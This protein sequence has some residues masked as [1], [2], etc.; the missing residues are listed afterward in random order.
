[1]KRPFWIICAVWLFVIAASACTLTTPNG[2][3]T[4]TMQPS[5]SFEEDVEVFGIGGTAL[6]DSNGNGR[7]DATDVPLAG[8]KFT[9]LDGSGKTKSGLTDDRGAVILGAP[10]GAVPIYPVTL[11]MEPPPGATY[12]VVGADEYTW[13]KVEL[14]RNGLGARFLFRLATP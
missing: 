5:P 8:A 6:V 2:A 3:A 13:S 14:V 1:M 10:N 7:I 12:Q 9:I 11:R 4:S